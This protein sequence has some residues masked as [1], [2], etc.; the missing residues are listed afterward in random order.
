M[1]HK[2]TSTGRLIGILRAI[3]EQCAK[4]LI[5][6]RG[7]VDHKTRPNIRIKAGIDDLEGPERRFAS[8]SLRQAGKKASL[9][10]KVPLL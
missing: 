8:V 10:P 7:D 5:D 4:T 1:G 9:I 2:E 6:E 3:G